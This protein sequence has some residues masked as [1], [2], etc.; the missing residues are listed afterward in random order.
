MPSGTA[1]A[2]DER[3][4]TG[5]SGPESLVSGYG[6][7]LLAVVSLG[8]LTVQGGRLVL[9]P[10]LP[11]L[12]ADL[13]IS[14]F[15]AGIALSTLWA[16]YALLQYPS[17][18]L[19]DRLSRKTLLVAGMGLAGAGFVLVSL[20]PTYPVFVAGA[21]VVGLGVGLYP[22]AARALIS[23][24]FVAK[25]GGAFGL[26][27]ASGDV[28]GGLAAG[29]AVVV[30]AVATW[31]AAFLPVVL[32]LAA[33][34]LSLHSLS[35]ESYVLTGVDLDFRGAGRRLL[36]DPDVR[37]LVAAY[38][39]FSFAWQATIGFLPTF[40]QAAK[41]LSPTLASTG[42]AGLFLVGATVK[43]LAGRLGDRGGKGRVAV[44]VMALGALALLTVVLAESRAVLIGATLVYAAGLMS[45]PPVMQSHLMDVFPDASM[46]ADLGMA[47]TTY[48]GIGSLG[49]AY[50]GFVADRAGYAPAF[51]GLVAALAVTA[52]VVRW[53]VS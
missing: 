8:W 10:L 41:G 25:R 20:A 32:V 9:S 23:D 48:I 35:R 44:G 43:P 4:D 31:R 2:A 11:A 6:G 51:A 53:R 16:C 33:A 17:G 18:R 29:L 49:P 26:H 34:V 22:T 21:A 38:A 7:R 28:G 46:G 19:S 14:S 40:L 52:V 12:I 13:N 50:V 30:L 42:F 37:W 5:E 3:V 15:E 27:T 36:A 39:C 45:F 47:R 1:D 24:H